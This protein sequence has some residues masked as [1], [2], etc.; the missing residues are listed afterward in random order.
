MTLI[1]TNDILKFARGTD[2]SAISDLHTVFFATDSEKIYYNGNAYTLGKSLSDA[3][4]SNNI[5]TSVSYLDPSV[6]GGNT[7]LSITYISPTGVVVTDPSIE[8]FGIDSSAD[9]AINTEYNTAT[10]KYQVNLKIKSGENVISQSSDGLFSNIGL[11]SNGYVYSLVGIDGTTPLGET[12]D[13]SKL[14]QDRFVKSG[15]M[16]TSDT[17][18]YAN[19]GD[20]VQLGP[21]TY[22]KLVL[23]LDTS[24]AAGD[25]S[26]N[27]SY[28]NVYINVEDLIEQY[29]AGNGINI[30]DATP[31]TNG[32]VTI[33]LKLNSTNDSSGYFSVSKSGAGFNSTALWTDVN[34]QIGTSISS[35]KQNIDNY[36]V[37]GKKI[38]TNPV[39]GGA[40]IATGTIG[41]VTNSTLSSGDALNVTVAKLQ[42]QILDSSNISGNT[43]SSLSALH[44]E[45]DDL[46]MATVG[47][48]DTSFG[49]AF[50]GTSYAHGIDSSSASLAAAIKNVDRGITLS[51]GNYSV[52]NKPLST[53]PVLGSSDI[54]ISSKPATGALASGNSVQDDMN[55]I[56]DAIT[57][58]TVG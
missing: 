1:K 3:L 38:S 41:T 34:A 45:V 35:A 2:S 7:R 50:V 33:S 54:G 9:N 11:K 49:N 17:S 8:L 32:G 46:E 57:W 56:N 22:L 16:V 26:N 44:N 14:T 18:F 47:Q 27:D 6:T 51:F 15:T 29:T 53:N 30:N 40:D 36:T 39:L 4:N 20:T 55:I 43:D 21:G 24:T 52:N 42:K 23:A 28:T 13:L 37:N 58:W 12:I 48:N 5:V 10:N 31:Y 19:T 25:P